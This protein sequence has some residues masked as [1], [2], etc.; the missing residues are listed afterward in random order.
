MSARQVA[1]L[2]G[3]EARHSSRGTLFIF[4]VLMPVVISLLLAVLFGSLFSG[5]PRLA[6]ADAGDSRLV[7]LAAAE[8][9]IVARSY[10]DAEDLRAAVADGAADIGVVLPADFDAALQAGRPVEVTAY[11]W[12][13]SLASDRALLGM[14]IARLARDVVGQEVPIDITTVTLGEASLPLADRLLPFVILIAMIFGGTLLPASSLVEERQSGTL[15]AVAVTSSTVRD[16]VIAK[17]L[18]GVAIALIMAVVTLVLNRALGGEPGLLVLVLLLGAILA[19]EFGILLG[20][21]ARDVTTLF[22][23]VKAIG[24]LLYAPALVT[25][26]PGVPQWIGRLFPTYYIVTPVLALT[27]QGAGWADIA[28]DVAVLFALDVVLLAAVA[29][30]LRRARLSLA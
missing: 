21:V 28:P 29:V 22:A 5:R 12:G 25:L 18:M 7:S 6:I 26:F 30:I 9:A 16:V 2:L 19:A 8:P 15:R 10:D 13:E 1:I 11:V 24:L 3:K 17:A 4:A 27:Q 20:L 14:T 23:T